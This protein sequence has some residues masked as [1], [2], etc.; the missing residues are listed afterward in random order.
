MR[1]AQNMLGWGVGPRI[2]TLH[3]RTRALDSRFPMTAA[4]LKKR[5]QGEYVPDEKSAVAWNGGTTEGC[6]TPRQVGQSGVICQV[7]QRNMGEGGW[8]PSATHVA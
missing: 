6:C 4:T 5:R 7:W 1:G 3:M 8:G 2:K